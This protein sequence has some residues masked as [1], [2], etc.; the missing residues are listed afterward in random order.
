MPEKKTITK[1]VIKKTTSEEKKPIEVVKNKTVK[2]AA[3][4]KISTKKVVVKKETGKKPPFKKKFF[5]KPP[6][7]WEA[8][9][10]RKR[11]VARVRL[12][13]R[14]EKE[15]IVN[16]RSFGD[17]FPVLEIQNSVTAALRKMK[18]LDRFRIMVKVRGGGIRGQA[19]ATRHGIA[20]ALVKFNPD[21]KKR[22][23]KAGYLT[24]DS[25]EKERRK[26]GLK[27]ARRAPQWQ[28]R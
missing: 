16:N 14:G 28:K 22:L 18:N 15:I 23:R 20:R 24:R 27:K 13:T 2:K 5:K 25:R 6:R 8:V 21:F 19:E 26:F 1:K 12:F 4:K 10:R 3:T 9:G 7:Y 17:Y 11:S